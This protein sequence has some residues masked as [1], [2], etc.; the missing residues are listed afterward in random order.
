[1]KRSPNGITVDPAYVLYSD[2]DDPADR[3]VAAVKRDW[4]Q[5]I[6]TDLEACKYPITGAMLTRL[7]RYTNSAEAT[8]RR[9]EYGD[10]RRSAQLEG[11]KSE[12]PQ[13]EPGAEPVSAGEAPQKKRPRTGADLHRNSGS[14]PM[15]SLPVT[16]RARRPSCPVDRFV[17]EEVQSRS[18]R[19]A[20][21]G[22]IVCA[23]ASP[24]ESDPGARN[25]LGFAQDVAAE[26]VSFQRLVAHTFGPDGAL[27]TRRECAMG[28]DY[29]VSPGRAPTSLPSSQD[30]AHGV[31]GV[32]EDFQR[33]TAEAL[34]RLRD[35][36]D[37]GYLD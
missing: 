34:Q 3:R 33:H 7:T 36:L 4:W 25:T 35:Y 28:S 31:V 15:A 27:F 30:W 20:A 9:K 12:R 16:D 8:L 19:Q 18:R 11:V 29:A 6:L 37:F 22:S 17:P 32:L 23:G 14:V 26:A 21:E 10:S 2:Y 13:P 5:G 24:A 1:V